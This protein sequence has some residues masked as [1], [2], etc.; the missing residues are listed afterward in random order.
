VERLDDYP[1]GDLDLA[2]TFLATVTFMRSWR[3]GFLLGMAV[4]LLRALWMPGAI[5]QYST[6]TLFLIDMLRIG[7]G[8]AA[9]FALLDLSLGFVL[10]IYR[11][12]RG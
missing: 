11:R 8:F 2:S 4:T 1:F 7:L 10:F 3:I 9:I 12:L 6:T 5:E